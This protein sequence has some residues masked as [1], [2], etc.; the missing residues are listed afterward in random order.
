MSRG[1]GQ[2]ERA[3][4]EALDWDKRGALS[5]GARV[6]D[7]V[8]YVRVVKAT[9]S[10]EAFRSVDDPWKGHNGGH[11]PPTRSEIESVRRALRNLRKQGLLPPPIKYRHV[12]YKPLRKKRQS[13]AP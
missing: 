12:V 1:H 13:L 5:M 7:L 11:P 4:L 9:G 8:C 10:G 3:I 6:N 2:I